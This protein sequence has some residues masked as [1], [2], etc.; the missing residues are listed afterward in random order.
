MNHVSLLKENLQKKH[1]VGVWLRLDRLKPA[2]ETFYPSQ[3]CLFVVS[4]LTCL[5]ARAD[6]CGL[7]RMSFPPSS[8][9]I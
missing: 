7:L 9:G 2:D 3:A 6:G 4:S 8:G 1:N 5:R